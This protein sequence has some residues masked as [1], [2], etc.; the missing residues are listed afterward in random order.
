MVTVDNARSKPNRR[1]H[2][3]RLA[4]RLDVDRV[5][6]VDAVHGEALPSTDTGDAPGG[7]LR[8]VTWAHCDVTETPGELSGPALAG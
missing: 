6:T 3:A 1:S 2:P 4:I 7:G 8:D 5:A